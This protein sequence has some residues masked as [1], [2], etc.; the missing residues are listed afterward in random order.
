[1]RR[2]RHDEVCRA[3]T[4]IEVLVVAVIMAIAGAIVVPQMLDTGT[5][6]LQA[7]SRMIIADILFAQNEAISQQLPHRI[8]F[9]PATE[10]YRLSDQAGNT[11]AVSWKGGGVTENYMVDFV[12]DSRFR[13]VV[14]TSA[15]FGSSHVLEFDEL[16]APITGGSIDLEFNL[17]RYRV[18]VANFTGRVS[19]Q[20]M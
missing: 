3:F 19:V 8:V 18:T 15:D 14:M 1:M 6:K 17:D 5:M 7:A 11:L 9:D 12:H 2:I 4:L 13:G 20:K 10:S 16:G